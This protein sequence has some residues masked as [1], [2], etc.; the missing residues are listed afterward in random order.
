MSPNITSHTRYNYPNQYDVIVIGAGHAGCEAALASARM[1]CKTLIATLNLD[2]IGQMSCNP[3]IG[4]LAKS[5]IVREI[6]ALGGEMAKNIDKTAIQYRMLNTKRGP[7]VWSL[8]A[9]A[10]RKAYQQSMKFVLETSENLDMIQA[11]IID[12]VVAKG[13]NAPYKIIGVQTRTGLVIQS[14]CVV[15]TTGTFMNGLIHIGPTQLAGGRIAEPASIGL[16][17]ALRRLGLGLGRLKTGTPPRINGQG[18]E[19][20]KVTEQPP[21]EHKEFFSYSTEDVNQPQVPCY[22]TYT[23]KNTH[24]I[25]HDNLNRAPLYTGQIK[26]VGPRYCPSIEVKIVKFADKDRHQIFIEPEGLHTTEMYLNGLAT[27]LPQDVQIAMLRTIPGLA[28]AHI[29]KFGYA[30]EYDFVFPTQ[31]YPYLEAKQIENLFLAGQINGTTG[32]EE[33]A[34]QGIMAGINAVLKIRR[35]APF[36]L[37]RAQA[38][39]GV[40]ID[41]L[42]TKGTEEPYRM[43]TSLAEYRLLLRQD[44]ADMRL[45]SFGHKFGLISDRQMRLLEEKKQQIESLIMLLQTTR[46]QEKTCAELLKRPEIRLSHL[47]EALFAD[48]GP[49]VLRAVEMQVKYEGYIQR[50][51]LRARKL[52]KL[53]NKSIPTT[54]D[55]NQVYGLKREAAEK[56]KNIKPVSLGQA[57]RISGISP[58][59]IS[60]ILAHLERK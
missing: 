47:P 39:I 43:F 28:K 29:V 15:V 25:I 9:Q 52:K 49:D 10:D 36:I 56:L 58:C 11:E 33:A 20:D 19:Y 59:D 17:D 23:N 18:I 35:E 53:E 51:V 14:K 16:S 37:D 34:G 60:L 30:I 48:Y 2:S 24:K 8:R 26:S 6:D 32:Y 41:D 46:H 27:S 3:A 7:A 38:Y 4:G 42:V 22:V 13:E 55:Y 21:D 1:G 31:L 57:S 12:F 40:L 45:A 50:D 44:N 54:F 5:H